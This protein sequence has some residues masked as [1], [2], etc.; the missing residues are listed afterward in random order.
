MEITVLVV[1]DEFLIAMDVQDMLESHGW[2][3]MGPVASVPEAL[4]LLRVALP[5]VA[6]LDVNLG[7]RMVTPVAEALRT[8]RV[9]FAVAS[10]YPRPEEL[11]G[12]V[13]LG[14]PIIR[15]PYSERQ[16]IP[17]LQQLLGESGRAK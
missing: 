1:E 9:P 15:K 11:G 17:T 10:A 14:A 3:V 13:L 5:N 7:G 6:M 4:E 16:I 2:K 12:A 8:A